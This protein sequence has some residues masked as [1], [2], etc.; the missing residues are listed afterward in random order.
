MKKDYS[1]AVL[2]T[3]VVSGCA[4]FNAGTDMQYGREAFIVGHDKT[5][6]SYFRK[7]AQM[8]PNVNYDDLPEGVWSYLGRA[9]H[10]DGELTQARKS[11]QRARGGFQT[12]L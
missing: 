5:A 12:R 9:E 10:A 1:I 8:D 11:L 4:A 3:I 6:E 2:L 7:A